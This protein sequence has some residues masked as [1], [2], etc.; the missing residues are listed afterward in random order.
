MHSGGTRSGVLERENEKDRYQEAY[1]ELCQRDPIAS[2]DETTT[3][4]PSQ[5]Y[6]QLDKLLEE[7]RHLR[8]QNPK[9]D[10]DKK[11]YQPRRLIEQ[12]KID[13]VC[14]G[15]LGLLIGTQ[16]LMKYILFLKM[17]KREVLI[18]NDIHLDHEEMHRLEKGHQDL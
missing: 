3:E 14:P 15:L 8:E 18:I 6:R 9:R 2:M 11:K 17:K 1:K 12:G 13:L 7:R 4:Y 5:D 16:L 10:L